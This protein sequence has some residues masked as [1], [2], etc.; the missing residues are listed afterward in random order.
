MW[1]ATNIT[2]TCHYVDAVSGSSSVALTTSVPAGSE[3]GNAVASAGGVTA[4]DDAG[5]CAPSPSDVAGNKVDRLAPSIAI[6]QPQATEYTLNAA[7][8]A[9]YSCHDG[10]S[11]VAACAGPV[12]N[13]ESVDTSTIGAH[14]F[15]VA[16]SDAVGNDRTA[17]VT[18]YV[19]YGVCLLY[20][21]DQ[22]A[23][24]GNSTIP[25]K[26]ELC[27]ANRADQSSSALR[28][29]AVQLAGPS[30]N[31]PNNAGQSGKDFRFDATLGQGGGY[32]YNLSTK[33]LVSGSYS[34]VFTVENEAGGLTHVAPFTVG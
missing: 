29:T 22:P 6:A 25:I 9:S 3:D 33:G 11:G 24:N 32:I 30:T 26:I 19:G 16:A 1:H 23:K 34:L 4:C 15:S 21:P 2:L 17:S 10:G 31:L 18:Y 13:G 12:A 5:N 27:D 14:T 20:N 7:Q 8:S 28:V